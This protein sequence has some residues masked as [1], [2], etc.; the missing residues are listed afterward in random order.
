MAD[1]RELIA[2]AQA[3][4]DIEASGEWFADLEDGRG[5]ERAHAEFI[6]ACSPWAVLALLDELE[7]SVITDEMVDD[8]A[9]ALWDARRSP[10][11]H[12]WDAIVEGGLNRPYPTFPHLVDDIRREARAALHAVVGANEEDQ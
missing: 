6:E 10:T 1:N 7:R 12:T 5:F 4:I 3:S 2:E 9:R 11:N 8:A